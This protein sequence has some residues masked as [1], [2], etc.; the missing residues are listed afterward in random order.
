MTAKM[1]RCF[2]DTNIWL[3]ALIEPADITK[4]SKAKQ[5]IASH[6]VVLRTQ[7]INEINVNLIRKAQFTEEQ[8][9]ELVTD[10]YETYLVVELDKTVQV[11][12]SE[13]RERYQLSFW[14]ST[15]VANALLVEADTLY[16]EDMQ[17]G[18]VVEGKMT[19][20]NPLK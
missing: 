18:F 16:S 3:Y 12:A 7:V 14:D 5:T 8:I 17:D 2:I 1:T 13:L 15:I 10:L 6:D 9:R 4:T 11:K 19:I 20:R